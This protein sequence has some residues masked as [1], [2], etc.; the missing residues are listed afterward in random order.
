MPI[1]IVSFPAQIDHLRTVGGAV[2]EHQRAG[3]SPSASRREGDADTAAILRC[4]A[5]TAGIGFRKLAGN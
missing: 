4:Q 5:G 2:H 3:S 1:P